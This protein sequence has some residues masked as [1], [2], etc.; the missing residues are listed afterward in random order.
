MEEKKEIKKELT[1]EQLEKTAG[2]DWDGHHNCGI[3]GSEMK[4]QRTQEGYCPAVYVCPICGNI[5]VFPY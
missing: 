2:G 3:C 4:F 5:D 1:P